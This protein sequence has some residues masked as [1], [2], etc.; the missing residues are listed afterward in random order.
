MIPVFTVDVF[1]TWAWALWLDRY[2]YRVSGDTCQYWWVSVSA[3]ADTSRPVIRLPVSTSQHCC[4]ARLQFQA[5]TVFS[6]I[7]PSY[8]Y[9]LHT[10][11][12]RTKSYFQY[13]KFVQ[14]GIGITAADSIGR[15]HGIGPTLMGACP[16]YP[17]GYSRH[18]CSQP[19]NTGSMYRA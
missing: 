3:G 5:Y 13:K 8:I 12:P 15:L 18:L 10:P 14:P 16:H 19:M 1:D 9:N 6:C 2:W 4:N 7:Y 17:C 11:I